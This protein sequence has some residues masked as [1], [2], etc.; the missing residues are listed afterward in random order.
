M[1]LSRE[2]YIKLCPGYTKILIYVIWWTKQRDQILHG[3]WWKLWSHDTDIT[4]NQLNLLQIN[5]FYYIQ[6]MIGA[7][8]KFLGTSGLL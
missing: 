5:K 4:E 8:L 3:H 2:I 1:S 6:I 7:C